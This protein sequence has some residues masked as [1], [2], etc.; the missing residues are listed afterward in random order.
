MCAR[1]ALCSL[2]C[3]GVW[4]ERR[5]RARAGQPHIHRGDIGHVPTADVVVERG[6]V[7]E[8][9]LRQG[10]ARCDRVAGECGG[11]VWRPRRDVQSALCGRVSSHGGGEPA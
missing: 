5:V 10:C 3:V 4:G 11:R 7:L 6:G 1:R 2:T 8:H 9:T